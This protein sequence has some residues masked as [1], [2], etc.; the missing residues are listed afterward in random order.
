MQCTQFREIL[1]DLQLKNVEPARET[2]A[3]SHASACQACGAV[4]AAERDLD[5]LLA[6]AA[7]TVRPPPGAAAQ[8]WRS[9]VGGPPP[10]AKWLATAA[11]VL[12]LA[13][14]GVLPFVLGGDAS[15][16]ALVTRA[17][18]LHRLAAAA[19]APR[20]CGEPDP[21]LVAGEGHGPEAALLPRTARRGWRFADAHADTGAVGGVR[22]TFRKRDLLLTCLMVPDRGYTL[23]PATQANGHTYHV[24]TTP[25][26]S[27]L[28]QRLA[29]GRLCV[30]TANVDAPTLADLALS[31]DAA[32]PATEAASS[33]PVVW[34][35]GDVHCDRCGA[36]VRATLERV[37]GIASV[38]V[39][40]AKDGSAE[41]GLKL[42]LAARVRDRG[43]VLDAARAA[44]ADA[45]FPVMADR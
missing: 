8:A 25:G 24:F 43:P 3:R 6:A 26:L 33:T 5:A 21:R 18:E 15:A 41:R 9:M 4:L 29:D 32:A 27:H 11:A 34:R 10:V 17:V 12:L 22:L 30:L 1:P 23:G 20:C 7:A 14:V 45:G 36:V 35:V 38:A 19:P 13:A 28:V 44:L 2:E 37:D 42:W 39:E 31:A 16:D 40:P